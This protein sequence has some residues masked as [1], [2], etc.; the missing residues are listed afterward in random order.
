MIYILLTAVI[1]LA[2]ILAITFRAYDRQMREFEKLKQ[3]HESWEAR[4]RHK[5]VTIIEEARDKAMEVLEE[6]RIEAES[7]RDSMS[8][9]LDGVGDKELQDYKL[10]LQ[11][12]SKAIEDGAQKEMM[13]FRKTLEVETVEAQK[14]IGQRIESEYSQMLAEVE[15]EKKRRLADLERKLTAVIKQAAST[16]VGKSLIPEEHTQ[17][18]IDSLMEAKQR[19]VL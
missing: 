15:E 13:E 9:K 6:A 1:V 3:E 17:L 19:N 2:G 11:N 5:A 16:V 8:R 18:I 10:V 14:V 4:A 12:I 7:K